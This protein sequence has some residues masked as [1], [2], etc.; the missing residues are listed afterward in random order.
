MAPSDVADVARAHVRAWQEAYRGLMPDAYLDGLDLDRR[1]AGWRRSWERGLPGYGVLVPVLDGGV[2]GFAGTGPC[3]DEGFGGL[4]ELYA[5]N[6]HPDAWGRGAGSALLRAAEQV[7]TERGHAEAVLWVVPGNTRA[8][9][10][11][12]RHGWVADGER[13][14]LEVMDGVAVDE[15][16]YRREL[17][18][19]ER[20]EA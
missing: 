18:A 20:A 3:R 12:E 19:A 5:I 14:T 6:L 4:G 7:L 10:F 8:R 15:M 1:I 13:R 9:R 16:R 11:Y 17:P 2:V